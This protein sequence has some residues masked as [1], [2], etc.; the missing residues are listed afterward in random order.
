MGQ[1]GGL[2]FNIESDIKRWG[3]VCYC[4]HGDALD[5][6]KR[7]RSNRLERHS[8]PFALVPAEIATATEATEAPAGAST[9]VDTSDA[10]SGD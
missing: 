5:A 7:D 6:G 3:R 4:P 2:G 8:A 10:P 9:R 1:G